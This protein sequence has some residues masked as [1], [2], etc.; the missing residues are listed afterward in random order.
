MNRKQN[1]FTLIEMLV[2]VA[3]I[4]VLIALLL[5]SLHKANLK[6]KQS[7]CLANISQLGMAWNSY[8][9]EAKGRVM[10][11]TLQAKDRALWTQLLRPHLGEDHSFMI[12]PETLDPPGYRAGEPGAGS[13]R[14][15][16]AKIAWVEDRG[17]YLAPDPWNRASYCYNGNMFSKSSYNTNKERFGY[18]ATIEDKHVVPLLGDGIWRS[19]TPG[20]LGRTLKVFP[21]NLSDPAQGMGSYDSVSRWVSNR[22]GHSTNLLF[23]DGHAERV[24]LNNMWS[25]K[26]HRYYDRVDYVD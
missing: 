7:V 10:E 20:A 19:Q 15:G 8:T 12:C 25:F 3:I 23:V 14:F 13:Y 22:H 21:I 24:P 1:G 16:T 18:V 11:Y 2:V 17:G 9:V 5:P 4:V 26:W 6:A